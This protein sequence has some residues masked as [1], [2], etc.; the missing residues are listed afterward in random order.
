[1]SGLAGF[2]FGVKLRDSLTVTAEALHTNGPTNLSQM[3]NTGLF[4]AKLIENLN[5]GWWSVHAF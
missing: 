5:E 2:A 1:M 3:S 4:G